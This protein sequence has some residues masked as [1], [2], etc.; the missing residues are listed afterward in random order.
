LNTTNA[1]T[2]WNVQNTDVNVFIRSIDF[3]NVSKGF[4]AG[5]G[6]TILATNTGGTNWSQQSSGTLSNF[7]SVCVLD[8][9]NA[10][11]VGENGTI[12]KTTTGGVT[13]KIL[14]LNTLLEGSYNPGANTMVG[15]TAITYLRKSSSPY[16]IVDSSI[17]TLTNSGA[18]TFSF[19]NVQNGTYYFLVIKHRNSVETWSS[20]GM[21]FVSDILSYD[22][23]DSS[24]RAFGDNLSLKGTRWTIFSGDVNQ[25]G[26][27]D[28]TDT[29]L[30]DNDAFGFVSGYIYTDLNGDN[31]ADAT[32]LGIAENNSSNFVS[33]IRP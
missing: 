16:S 5:D 32:D 11:A 19:L 23:T 31:F 10:W 15:D 27:I 25:D 22:F 18:G 8:P 3:A 33:V 20:T 9:L 12:R 24:S 21:S 17:S 30:I 28:A 1:G 2:N 29:G 26:I 6:G 14:T 13:P 7:Y 4:A